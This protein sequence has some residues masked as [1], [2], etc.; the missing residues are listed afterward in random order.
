MTEKKINVLLVDDEEAL[1]HSMKRRLEFR[2]FTVIAA[3]S[4]E[5]ALEVA[6]E[7]PV[8]VAVVDIKMPGMDGREVM[9]AL[10][11]EYPWI[12]V[13]VLTGHG[14]F[15]PEEEGISGK[16]HACLAKPCNFG[17]LQ[18]ALVD[19]YKKTVMNRKRLDPSEMDALLGEESD[20][21]P[22]SILKKLKDV[23]DNR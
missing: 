1:L 11:K 4:G 9:K 13:I 3:G 19:A 8:D 15:D 10:K 12:E 22:D 23:D 17:T 14:S 7:T 2:D 20:G 16:I 18:Q 6:R 5:K 21:S